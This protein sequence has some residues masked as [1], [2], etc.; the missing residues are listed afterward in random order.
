MRTSG[1]QS[2]AT[3]GRGPG[4]TN[5]N[6]TRPYRQDALRSAPCLCLW[7]L[8]SS[9]LG[10]TST[11]LH[12][13][14]GA[15]LRRLV[16]TFPCSQAD[17]PLSC[18]EGRGVLPGDDGS[19]TEPTAHPAGCQKTPLVCIRT[20]P[21]HCPPWETL[22]HRRPTNG[23][24][25]AR[26]APVVRTKDST[27]PPVCPAGS[28]RLSCTGLRTTCGGCKAPLSPHKAPLSPRCCA[29]GGRA[30]RPAVQ[31]TKESSRGD[32]VVRVRQRQHPSML[33]GTRANAR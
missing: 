6:R 4:D 19:L 33:H 24:R 14:L 3:P 5:P 28:D 1:G 25:S 2:C 16:P 20:K 9:P 15:G 13:A 12:K 23:H 22:P 32:A 18:M 8:R 17:I 7:A 29:G 11:A 21:P 30:Q 10:S 31:Q 27:A 26:A